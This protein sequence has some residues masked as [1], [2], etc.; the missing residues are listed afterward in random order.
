M[1]KK[2]LAATPRIRIQ[3]KDGYRYD[4]FCYTVF[5][6]SGCL[7]DDGSRHG[8]I[9]FGILDGVDNLGSIQR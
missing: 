8:I 6:V 2:G 7:N 3:S 4:L 9:Q 5:L 1:K